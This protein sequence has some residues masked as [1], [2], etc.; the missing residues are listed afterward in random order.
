MVVL[1]GN[2]SVTVSRF[3]PNA[4]VPSFYN[5]NNQVFNNAADRMTT[6]YVLARGSWVSESRFGWNN[7]SLERA[8]D[9]WFVS[10]PA[11][12]AESAFTNPG[13]RMSNLTVSGL[14]QTAPAQVLDM[15]NHSFNVDQKLGRV[16]GAHNVKVG[17]RWM[18]EGGSK[19]NPEA[20]R[21][22][23]LTLA[24]LFTN[25][26]SAALVLYGQPPHFIRMDQWGGFMQD[27]W[28][29]SN[30]LMLNL[31]L[32]YDY[33]P[34]TRHRPTTDT[35][36]E[37]VN[38]DPPTDLRKMDFGAQRDQN[39]V[40]EPDRIN[41]GPRFGFAWTL[42]EEGK[43]VIRGGVGVLYS[44]QLLALFQNVISDPLVPARV[45]WNRT[46]IAAKD[47]KWP[48]YS[49]DL[50]NIV[51]RDSGGTTRL[52]GII[53]PNIRNPRTIQSM[54][55]VQRAIGSSWM[56]A[57][58][59][60]H[61]AGSDFPMSR[62]FQTAFDRETGAR[63]NPALGN[64]SGYYIDSSQTM[65]YDG[66]EG[67]I[68]KRLSNNLEFGF[69]YTLS[70]GWAQQGGDLNGNFSRG[71]ADTWSTTQDFW[72]PN[73]ERDRAPLSD[74]V[75]HRVTGQAIYE[76]PWFRE[77][78]GVLSQ[79]L[80]GW[81]I[82]GVFNARSGLPL[83]IA[84]LS[85]IPES[86][87]DYIGGNPVFPDWRDTRVYLNPAAFARV[88]TYPATNATIRPGTQNPSQVHGPG[89]KTVN[90]A[91]AKNVRLGEQMSLQVRA[92]VFNALNQVNYRAPDLSIL[93]PDFGKL[94]AAAEAR[95]GQIG[96]R[97]A[98]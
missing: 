50:R 66:F 65:V 45:N 58:S 31:G 76:L 28:R 34:A 8:Q 32:R 84:Q 5:G 47:I 30:K 56:V 97:L 7:S 48:I 6:Q 60:V 36:A 23:Y 77:G 94:T 53:D 20:A 17:F 72:D 67:N 85:G 93:S 71:N 44:P 38:L 1:G 73:A 46:E 10:D 69:H 22:T 83:R 86:R 41:L 21:L 82:S 4:V 61:T 3:R 98:F 59:Y 63:P 37:I 16:M 80:G 25:T 68:R 18:R 42:D 35:P 89:R 24:D 12:P 57:G 11:R 29:V 54:I 14:F 91:V 39:N 64:P 62:F 2:L 79:I 52:Y 96:V 87:P 40:Y 74:E 27:D 78:R 43:T 75:R 26:P 33:Y 49:D 51:L 9:F 70:K 15:K 88:P 81:Q 92:E 55:D 19:T 13:R 95:T 90:I